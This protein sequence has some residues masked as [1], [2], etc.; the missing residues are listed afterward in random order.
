MNKA[1]WNKQTLILK[2][3]NE[4]YM[5]LNYGEQTIDMLRNTFLNTAIELEV[6]I[7]IEN[8]W[9]TESWSKEISLKYLI[10][11]S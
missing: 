7:L 8:T 11:I 3:G 6:I 5:T 10:E 4:K 2:G 9:V 1:A